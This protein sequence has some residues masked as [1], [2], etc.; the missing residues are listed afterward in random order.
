MRKTLAGLFFLLITVFVFAGDNY[1]VPLMKN[2]PKIDGYIDEN[3]WKEAIRFDGF[4]F[5]GRLQP[6]KTVGFIGAAEDTVYVAILSELPPDGKLITNIKSSTEK[7]VYDDAVEVWLDPYA[8]KEDGVTYQ[9]LCNSEGYAYYLTHLRGNIKPE[10]IYGWKGNYNIKNGLHDGFWHC[11][12]EIPVKNLYKV[13]KTTDREWLINICR[14]YKRPGGWSAIGEEKYVFTSVNRII[15]NFSGDDGIIVR[16]KHLKDPY[17]GKIDYIVELYNPLNKKIEGKVKILLHRDLMPEVSKT[18]KFL[19]NP[20]EQKYIKFEIED[21]TS[22]KMGLDTFVTSLDD[23]KTYFSRKYTFDNWKQ[24]KEKWSISL[25]KQKEIPV[26]N[27]SFSHYP[28]LKKMKILADITGSEGKA[29]IEKLNFVIREE[30]TKKEIKKITFE[31]DEFKNWKCEKLIDLPDLNGVYE[32]AVKAVGEN[33]PEGEVVRRFERKVFEWEHND[34]GKSRK[35][36][37]P[38]T[39]IKKEGDK[40]YTVLKEYRINNLGLLSSVITEDQQRI[41]KKEIL[42][43]DMGYR[44]KAGNKEIKSRKGELRYKEV[45]EDR[46]IMESK[47]KIGDIEVNS[48]S[49]LEYDGMLKVDLTLNPCEEQIDELILE[50]PIRNDIAKLMHAMADGIRSPILTGQIPSGQ[51]LVWDATKIMP[52]AFPSNFCTYIYLGDEHRGISWFS[53]NDRGWSWDNKKPNLQIVREKDVLK[54]EINLINKPT[55]ITKAQTIT[56]G[57]MAAPV[58]PR[59]E[60]WRYRWISEKFDLIATDSV[61]FGYPSCCSVYPLGRDIYLW[62]ILGK[63]HRGEKI[64]EGEI[65]TLKEKLIKYTEPYGK[66]MV[67]RYTGSMMAKIGMQRN[68]RNTVF[69]FNRASFPAAEEFQTFMDEWCLN[70]YNTDLRNAK[71]ISEI[72]IVPTDS[73]I[74][75][76]LWWYKKAIE[77]A[78]AKVIYWDNYFFIPS[79]NTM[80]TSAYKKEDGSIMPSTGLWGLRELVKRTFVMM[81]EMGV[82]PMTMVHMTSTQILPLYSFATIQF[83]LEWRYGEG[84]MQNRFSREYLR[85][86][87]SGDISGTWPILIGDMGKVAE[88]ERDRIQKSYIGVSLVHD[89]MDRPMSNLFYKYRKPFIDMAKD[90]KDLVV[91]RY[92]DE[93]QQPVYTKNKDLP[94]IV[95]SVWGKEA[96]YGVVSYLKE[97]A[98][99]TVFIESDKL[100]LSRYKVI[101][102]DTNQEI[103]V[104]NNTFKLNIKKHD[105]KVFRIIKN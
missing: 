71:F 64:T 47:F 88:G 9:M 86:V 40:I 92:W 41:N 101:D 42:A 67:E 72:M 85:L 60:G 57:I 4:S 32:I 37:P 91:Y 12:I 36:Y 53:E 95:Y 54:L 18:E 2:V 25:G 68:V 45:S 5:D 46:V 62:E 96:L 10:E 52:S 30:Q 28:Y 82:E 16:Q 49:Y 76:A 100:G 20:E 3:E 6:R 59:V 94:G 26:V 98:E 27:F 63:A 14:D 97:D 102:I 70:E 1:I 51:G 19:L 38:F 55:R 90:N 15:F 56:F 48:V 13:S 84:D 39:P 11:E 43:G 35:V 105:L 73:Y 7:I 80:M 93:R 21:D 34:L 89:L 87:S 24:P 75:H 61:W 29:K 66:E 31:K 83:D 8:G 69:Y 77:V 22:M 50:I 44:G 104:E 23:S 58:K 79:Y 99:E 65:E 78:G 17:L 74:D 103:P 33:V 81:N